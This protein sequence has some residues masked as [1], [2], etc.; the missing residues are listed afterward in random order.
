MYEF[1]VRGYNDGVA[2]GKVEFAALLEIELW[3][4][5][6]KQSSVVWLD[7]KNKVMWVTTYGGFH[8]R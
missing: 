3:L 6:H 7:F 8:Q 1:E 5:K 2:Y 4:A